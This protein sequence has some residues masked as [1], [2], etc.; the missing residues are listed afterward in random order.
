MTCIF[1]ILFQNTLQAS[2]PMSHHVQTGRLVCSF[3]IFYLYVRAVMLW[4]L[5]P[6]LHIQNIKFLSPKPKPTKNCYGDLSCFDLPDFK[7]K[8]A[9]QFKKVIKIRKGLRYADIDVYLCET[10]YRL[11]VEGQ[12]AL[13]HLIADYILS[14]KANK[15]IYKRFFGVADDWAYSP[16]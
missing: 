5:L 15:H 16:C 12:R 9:E 14:H 2:F 1:R 10:P 11:T 4:L 6:C 7:A 8:L 3:H 13:W